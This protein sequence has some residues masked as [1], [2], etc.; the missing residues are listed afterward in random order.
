MIVAPGFRQRA[1]GFSD[2]EAVDQAASL[3]WYE[4]T[5]N[6]W[7][8]SLDLNPVGAIERW[9]DEWLGY[10]FAGEGNDL[11]GWQRTLYGVAAFGVSGG[12]FAPSLGGSIGRAI[13]QRM[14]GADEAN[15]TY[16]LGGELKFN[17]P[18]PENTA[19]DMRRLKL[20]EMERAWI[21]SRVESGVV[22]VTAGLAGGFAGSLMD[23]LNVATA[24]LPV[25]WF[26]RIAAI[27]RLAQS[28]RVGAEIAAQA[29]QGTAGA[30]LIEPIIA[31]RAWR[32]QA[33]YTAADSALNILFGAGM[34]AFAPVAEAG[35]RA[36]AGRVAEFFPGAPAITRRLSEFSEGGIYRD[37]AGWLKEAPLPN[38]PTPPPLSM[39]NYWAERD[40]DGAVD[41]YLGRLAV[42]PDGTYIINSDLARE[43]ATDYSASPENRTRFSQSTYAP[44]SKIA[45]GAF[46]KALKDAPAGRVVFTAG[47]PGSGK[48]TAAN[49]INPSII[50]DGTLANYE[51]SKAQI[52]EAI[53]SGRGV[54]IAY[55]YRPL[56][57]SIIN[58]LNRAISP[59]GGRVVAAS[60][61]VNGYLNSRANVLR[62]S[63]E[64]GDD[65]VFRMADMTGN[66]PK[67]MT[68]EEVA[69]L[70]DLPVDELR[71]RAVNTINEWFRANQGRKGVTEELRSEAL[72]S[73][74]APRGSGPRGNSG[75]GS[76][77][78][79][80][81]G[82]GSA[83]SSRVLT[84]AQEAEFLERSIREQEIETNSAL[85]E[86]LATRLNEEELQRVVANLSE[87]RIQAAIISAR[88]TYDDIVSA[89]APAGEKRD[90][91]AALRKFVDE[92]NEYYG[93]RA[94]DPLPK[95]S[96]VFRGDTGIRDNVDTILG[97]MHPAVD[98]VSDALETLKSLSG[99][100][101]VERLTDGN[102]A[103]AILRRR[104]DLTFFQQNL[105]AETNGAIYRALSARIEEG[106]SLSSRE[107]EAMVNLDPN[108]IRAD[109]EAGR[110]M[111]MAE[112][113]LWKSEEPDRLMA[114]VRSPEQVIADAAATDALVAE[115]SSRRLLDFAKRVQ[116][117]EMGGGRLD[118]GSFR[119]PVRET[120]DLENS[121][122]L[123]R[124][125]ADLEAELLAVGDSTPIGRAL[126]SEMEAIK[127]AADE[128]AN[129]LPKIMKVLDDLRNC[130]FTP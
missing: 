116:S 30:I 75:G 29:L 53:A 42:R 7:G 45:D 84:R 57:E 85:A 94:Y 24:F 10:A 17:G 51:R 81:G 8:S 79:G 82:G 43:L 128:P 32:E 105:S 90:A 23:P 4:A 100:I 39:L 107:I 119:V 108:K 61:L 97:T 52:A 20:R 88:R 104:P 71:Q 40:L 13:P 83:S 22:S 103:P 122:A 60:S 114:D 59:D 50:V 117:G 27:S 35:L 130:V 98:S 127:L 109:I 1:F 47:S 73:Y 62:F 92:V 14:L 34:G 124:E 89:N 80:V 56:E 111:T 16:G 76:E 41:A 3:P 9:R 18:I 38:A 72:G 93:Y 96:R 112:F 6:G 28:S 69:S 44:A 2:Q 106:K 5:A 58:T 66:K 78:G 26:G 46:I 37:A 67:E 113:Q 15:E 48:S 102:G 55:V 74:A 120:P 115:E 54:S 21:G 86:A 19:K 99:K 87:H 65:V 110:K 25:G 129:R 126:K 95:S 118:A 33:D 121:A 36:G 49:A 64:F 31:S 125:I 68:I 101:N 123:S 63:K 77:S 11:P 70:P 91:L 12:A